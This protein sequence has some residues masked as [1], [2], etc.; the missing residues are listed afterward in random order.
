MPLLDDQR[1]AERDDVAGGADQ[2]V[3]L[4]GVEEG[5]E[6]ALRRLAGDRLQLDPAIRPMLRMSMTCGQSAANA[7]RPP[8]RAQ[9]GRA[10]EEAFFLVG[11]ER[12]SP[13]AEAIGLPE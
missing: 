11:L 10:F 4:V 2:H 6:G 7:P 3:V 13:A 5:R 1:R 8:S 9:V 12:A